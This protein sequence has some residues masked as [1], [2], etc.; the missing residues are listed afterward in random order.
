MT[1][2]LDLRYE[3]LRTAGFSDS[4]GERDDFAF[5]LL[6]AFNGVDPAKAPEVWQEYPN[7]WCMKAWQRVADAALKLVQTKPE[8]G[9]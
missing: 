6:C 5:A 8:S 1:H 9:E 3:R 4:V 7:K 2:E